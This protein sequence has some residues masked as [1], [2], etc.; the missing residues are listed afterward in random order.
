MRWGCC[1]DL[2]HTR[3]KRCLLPTQ[4]H[5]SQFRY[6]SWPRTNGPR[7]I[8]AMPHGGQLSWWLLNVCVPFY[9]SLNC[10]CRSAC[11]RSRR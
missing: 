8:Q 1:A 2:T 11:A 4:Q 10:L 5:A 3:V 7:Q 6:A 9:D